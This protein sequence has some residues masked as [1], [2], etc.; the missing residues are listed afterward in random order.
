VNHSD[1][2]VFSDA[3]PGVSILDADRWS[4]QLQLQF[5]VNY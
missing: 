3:R 2:P 1:R 4:H 5:V